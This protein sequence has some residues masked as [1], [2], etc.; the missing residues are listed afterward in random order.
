MDWNTNAHPA[1]DW[2]DEGKGRKGVAGIG[3]HLW[4]LMHAFRPC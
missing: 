1:S 2:T 3:L 4:S